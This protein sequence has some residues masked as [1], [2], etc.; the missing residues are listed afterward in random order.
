[1]SGGEERHGGGGQCDGKGWAGL[2]GGQWRSSVRCWDGAE[3]CRKSGE[4]PSDIWEEHPS[5][6]Q[7]PEV[8]LCSGNSEETSVGLQ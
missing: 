6:N 2:V 7:V 1:M 5:K 4:R 8:R 3:V